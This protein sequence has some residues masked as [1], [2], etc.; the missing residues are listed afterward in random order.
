VISGWALDRTAEF[1][2][3][4]DTVHVWAY[5]TNGGSPVFVGAS[6]LSTNRPDVAAIFG[7]Q[8]ARAGF[9]VRARGLPPGRYR[10]V[11]TPHS[12]GWR[13]FD[14]AAAR[15]V[16]ATITRP[17]TS[18]I[19]IAIDTLGAGTIAGP[20]M[21]I[22][23]WALD[24]ATSDGPGVDAIQIYAYP[25]SGA[26]PIFLGAGSYGGVRPDVAAI[27]G[28]SF[29]NVGYSLTVSVPLPGRYQLVVFARSTLSGLFSA[30][31]K[32]ITV[33]KAGRQA[34]WIDTPGNNATAESPFAIQGWAIDLDA[35]TLTGVDAIYGWAIPG[36]GGP[37]IFLGAGTY[38]SSRPDV[39]AAFGSQFTNSGYAVTVPRASL[40]AGVYT[41][42][43]FAHSS[44]TGRYNQTRSISVTVF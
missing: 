34:M 38:G 41:I 24:D 12:S 7:D 14:R 2:A 31:T 8:F 33:P 9:T 5:P 11:A 26:P 20:Q 3:G 23:G 40:P 32:D 27:F 25:G 37:S 44:V 13:E 15:S 30:A 28:T 43:V 39:G 21:T 29:T 4:I 18:H 6:E 16:T 22:A 36:T 19:E 42:V 35:R 10:F 17:Q 1:D